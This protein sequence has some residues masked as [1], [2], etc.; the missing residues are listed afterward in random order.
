MK[1]IVVIG[2]GFAGAYIAR[3]LEKDFDVTLIDSKDYFEFTPG[4]PRT[5]VEPEHIKKIQ[6]LHTNYLKKAGVIIECA[7]TLTEKEVK[8][9]NKRIKFD[10]LVICSGSSYNSPFKEKDIVI[11][12]RAKTLKN[13]SSKLE[14]AKKILIVGGGLVG[15]ELAAEI[16]THY[17]NKEIVIIHSKDRLIE[18]N[19]KEAS[20]Y[21]EKF[22]KKRGIKIIYNEIAVESNKYK[23]TTNKGS[24]LKADM[25]FLCTGIIPNFESMKKNFS[26]NLNESNQIKVNEYLQLTNHKNIFAAGDI[27]DI[28]EEKTAQNALRQARAVVKN[29]KAIENNKPLLIYKSKQAPLV[30][31]LGKYCGIFSWK[32]FV[33]TG[34]VPGILKTLIEKREMWKLK[35]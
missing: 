8:I 18:R 31:S 32:N 34:I 2:G 27:T 5:I 6:I 20:R 16:C 15:T 3:K 13:C 24:I 1:K 28:T 25:V 22:L 10:Y 9:K 14:K 33:F 17:K 4:I 12:T 7:T 30:I 29:I 35:L 11:L 23:F 21:A 19:S 26:K